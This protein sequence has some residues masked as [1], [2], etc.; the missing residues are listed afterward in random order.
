MF[1]Y[2]KAKS[3]KG[4]DWVYGRLVETLYT[5]YIIANYD[6]NRVYKYMVYNDSVKSFTGMCDRNGTKL[7]VD[8]VVIDKKGQYGIVFY[9]N[10]EYLIKWKMRDGSFEVDDCF[11][12]A[13]LV[14][15]NYVLR[16]NFRG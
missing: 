1:N 12:Y 2:Y 14:G 7:Y 3:I 5:K 15:N 4:G 10:D 8:D 16:M 13:I 9:R 11:D 6:G